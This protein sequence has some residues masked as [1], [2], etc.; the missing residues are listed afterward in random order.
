METRL[1]ATRYELGERLGSG[2]VAVV[3]R[4]RDRRLD[5]TCALKVLREEYAQDPEFLRRFER[6]ARL[7]AQLNH[8]N[9]VAVYDYGPLDGTFFIA[10]EYV[11]GGNLKDLLRAHGPL[12]AREVVR[13]GREVL[14]GLASAHAR[15]LVHR[16]VKPQ[17][18][19]LTADRTA[20]LGDFGIAHHSAT[21]QL[22]RTGMTLGTAAYVAPEQAQ[23]MAPS[24]S[25]DVYGVGLLLYEM[26]VGRPPF[27][28]ESA[29]AVVYRQVHEVPVPPGQLVAGV[30]P[31]LN[32]VVMR[33]L[34]KD[35][36]NRFL[37]AQVMLDALADPTI[38]DGWRRPG[39]SPLRAPVQPAGPSI[40]APASRAVVVAPVGPP[41]PR[42]RGGWLLPAVL[43]VILLLGAAYVAL[44]G[45][46]GAPSPAPSPTLA[47]TAR[48]TTAP[49]APAAAPPIHP[50]ARPTLQPPPAAPTAA[51]SPTAPRQSPPAASK[52]TAAT[53][54]PAPAAAPTTQPTPLPTRTA[55]AGAIVLEDTAFVGGYRNSGPSIYRQRTATWVYAANTPYSTM[56]A[57]FDLPVAPASGG[58]LTIVGLSSEHSR[59]RIS[60]AIN[61][62]QVYRGPSPFESDTLS[63]DFENA[64]APWTEVRWDLPPGVLRAGRNTIALS[65]LEPQG[66]VNQPPFVML[67]RATI[68]ARR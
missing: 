11:P 44:A 16:D 51:A 58:A 34:E 41:A 28:G 23:G 25:A 61:G 48:A 10:M 6:E 36:T 63:Q 52:P 66:G 56:T 4:A 18:V 50:T 68:E 33:A 20:K 39:S 26:L 59:P 8:P 37:S 19:L 12:S 30:S 7:A 49:T 15:G 5:R 31:A 2:G 47:A 1:V 21:T 64:P 65:N 45:R 55:P 27:E 67:D 53:P 40:A 60:L 54:P 14:G 3:Y 42:A 57:T 38:L 62:A 29:P 32:A 9:L 13:I 35:P 46:G 17:N 24:P 43:L 22:T